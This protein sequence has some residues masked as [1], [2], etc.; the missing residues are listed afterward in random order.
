MIETGPCIYLIHK[1]SYIVHTLSFSHTKFHHS[2]F[3]THLPLY[4]SSS[5]PLQRQNLET[6]EPANPS[7]L[8]RNSFF[9]RCR[10]QVS[11]FPSFPFF[12]FYFP[13][14]LHDNPGPRRESKEKNNSH[15]LSLTLTSVRLP[16]EGKPTRKKQYR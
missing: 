13:S 3:H 12:F 11:G 15:P 6:N 9:G 8:D 16:R 1:C 5:S 4:P 14:F 7:D 2:F 10:R